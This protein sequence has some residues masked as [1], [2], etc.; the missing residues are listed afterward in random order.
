MKTRTSALSRAAVVAGAIASVVAP[1]TALAQGSGRAPAAVGTRIADGQAY[2]VLVRLEHQPDPKNNGR[3]LLAFEENGLDGI[4]IWESTD[5]GASWHFVMHATDA[6]HT[7]H[8]TCNLHWQPHL[9]EMPR[10][11]GALQAGTIFLSA[12]A[13]CNNAAGRVAEQHLQLYTFHD[14]GRSWRFL[15]GY[16]DGTTALPV[17]EPFLV[18][19]DDGRWWSSTRA[20]PT[21]P[22]ATTSCSPTRSRPMAA[23]PGDL[24]SSTPP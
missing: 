7:D 13:V 5:E 6:V 3:L 2:A 19:L 8:T 9:T 23:R 14:L 4:P 22:T 16:A 1:G 10:T 21:R 20:R 18:I 15:S 17:W 24:K 11:I 12:S